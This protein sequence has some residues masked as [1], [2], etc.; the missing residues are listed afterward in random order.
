M[1]YFSEAVTRVI[2]RH[3]YSLD[4]LT[5]NIKSDGDPSRRESEINFAFLRGKTEGLREAMQ[6]L[7]EEYNKAREPQ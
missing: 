7:C 4:H 2:K 5:A 1:A 3:G 6:I